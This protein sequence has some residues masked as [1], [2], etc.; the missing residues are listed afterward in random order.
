M[1]DRLTRKQDRRKN[2]SDN[3][4]QNRDAK[5]RREKKSE[6]HQAL[7]QKQQEEKQARL[8]AQE[9]DNP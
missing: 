8:K 6:A 4:S 9:E 1:G 2:F 5:A 7:L 3:K